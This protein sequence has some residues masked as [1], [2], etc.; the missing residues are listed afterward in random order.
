M[1]IRP[2]RPEDLPWIATAADA[3]FSSV[4]PDYGTAVAAWATHPETLAWIAETSAEDGLIPIGFAIVGS[5][6][7]VGDDR[8]RIL[9]LQAIGVDPAHRRRGVA[10]SL[11]ARVLLQARGDAGT[12]EVRLHVAADQLAA[13]ALF[14]QAGFTVT[15]EDDGKFTNGD[16]AV[17]MN[18]EPRPD[19]R[20]RSR[21][22]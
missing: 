19:R 15:R 12:L 9:E 20:W 11:L 17:R 16:R 21:N 8:P 13:R 5:I 22:P 18:W 6:G 7:L 4:E 2:L 1:R 10:R 3:W 14:T